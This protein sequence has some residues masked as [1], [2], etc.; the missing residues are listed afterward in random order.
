MP[1]TF[2]PKTA[3]ALTDLLRAAYKVSH[4]YAGLVNESSE[5]FDENF[6]H[7]DEDNDNRI[8]AVVMIVAPLEDLHSAYARFNARMLDG[9]R[10]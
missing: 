9:G 7:R 1:I 10:R 8:G 3:E 4:L 6:V 2:G 5:V